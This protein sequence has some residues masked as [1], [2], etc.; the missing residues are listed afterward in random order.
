MGVGGQTFVLGDGF[1]LGVSL[2]PLG[3]FEDTGLGE[4]DGG[5]GEVSGVGFAEFYGFDLTCFKEFLVDIIQSKIQTRKYLIEKLAL[6]NL[7][8]PTV[9][10]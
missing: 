7:T 2:P 4:A 6:Q 5:H 3:V 10:Y 1:G 9:I 8:A